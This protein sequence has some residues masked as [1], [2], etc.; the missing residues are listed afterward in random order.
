MNAETTAIFTVQ[1][2][3]PDDVDDSTLWSDHDSAPG[4]PRHGDGDDDDDD[5]QAIG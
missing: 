5:W 1:P 4:S 2:T 3:R